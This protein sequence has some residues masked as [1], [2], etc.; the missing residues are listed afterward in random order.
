MSGNFNEFK[1]YINGKKVGV[2]GIGVSNKPV[3]RQLVA[4]GAQVIACD[5]RTD[6]GDEKKELESIGVRV[7]LGDDYLKSI[8][9]CQVI[10]RSPSMRPD[11]PYLKKA[12]NNG[13]LITSEM[14]QFL[15]YCPA[16]VIGVTGSDGKTTTT[17]L[18]NEML[19]AD[20]FN[21]FLGG[22][23]G[24][25]LLYRIEEI[26]PED[27][28]VVELSSFQLMDCHYSPQVA[29]ITNLSPNHLDIHKDMEEYVNAKKNIFLNQDGTGITILNMDNEVTFGMRGEPIG[30]VRMFSTKNDMAKAYVK[31][32][33]MYVDDKF[34]CAIDDVALPGMH[35]VE[36]LLAAFCA[37]YDVVS[38]EAMREVALNFTGVEHRIEYVREYK[39]IKFY[40][41]SIASSPTRVLAGLRYFKN[42]RKKKVIL[43]AGG[44]DKHIPFDELADEGMDKIKALILIGATKGKIRQAFEKKMKNK[45]EKFP[46]IDADSLADAVEKAIEQGEAGDIITLSPACA[47]FDM[48]KNFEERGKKFK[49]IVNS[50]EE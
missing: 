22:N 17:T 18:I 27:F 7:E 50:L 48:F 40:N 44:Y 13:A 2:V 12:R 11:N 20:G 39:G 8:P 36:N 38:I 30:S 34:I 45:S 42:E 25:P 26:K 32:G 24:D 29:V 3:I 19:K 14:E 43:I 49:E 41:D 35:N 6:I 31:D 10:F 46:I 21:T 37:V 28:V 1:S 23:I 15:K 33:K 47:A 5:R 16:K 4:L 9:G